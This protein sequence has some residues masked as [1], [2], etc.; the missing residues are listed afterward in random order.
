MRASQLGAR[1]LLIEKSS[2]GGTCLNRGCIPTKFLWEALHLESKIKK[3]SNYGISADLKAISFRDLIAKKNKTIEQLSKGT[4]QLLDSHSVTVIEGT[5]DFSAIKSINIASSN[6]EKNTY[7]CDKFII[8]AGSSPAGLH[9]YACDHKKVVDSTDILELEQ[10][11]KTLLVVGGGA[12]G[13]E[14]ASIFARLGSEVTLVEKEN[15]LLPGE[16][17]VLA[18]EVKKSLTRDGV[19]VNTSTGPFDDLAKASEKVLIAIGR[20]SNA[21]YLNLDKTAVRYS[22]KG[23][24]INKFL[25]TSQKGIYAAGDVTGSHYLAY[26]AQ[27]EG[28]CAAENAFGI[29]RVLNHDIIPKVVFSN[30]PA[31][32]VGNTN[33][34]SGNIITGSF[35]FAASSRAFIESERRGWV[36]IIAEK[37]SEKIVGGLVLGSCAE[38]LIAVIAIA[39]KTKMTLHDMTREIFFHPSLSEAIHCACEDALAKCVDLPKKI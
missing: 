28:I 10:S 34:K 26:I 24:E 31:A 12:I 36:K 19:K 33:I 7:Y 37:T 16:D 6:G 25:E 27:A 29:K 20:R 22:H 14:F 9:G 11:P 38:E 15:Q 21:P 1:V 2:A 3:A 35:S 8:A 13:V 39:V 5:A 30:P 32:S 17:P 23:I 4:K 18:D